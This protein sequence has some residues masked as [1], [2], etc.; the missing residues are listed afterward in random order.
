[1][2]RLRKELAC[3]DEAGKISEGAAL[4]WEKKGSRANMED[5]VFI[6]S[7]AKVKHTEQERKVLIENFCFI[8]NYEKNNNQSWGKESTDKGA[9]LSIIEGGWKL[10]LVKK[11]SNITRQCWKTLNVFFKLHVSTQRKKLQLYKRM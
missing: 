10:E 5:M 3:N 7:D 6:L 4:W 1:M 2:D 9:K 11:S 8:R